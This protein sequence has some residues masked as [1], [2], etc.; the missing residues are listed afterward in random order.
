VTS[1]SASPI[2]VAITGAL[3]GAAVMTTAR[4]QRKIW[5]SSFER[6]GAAS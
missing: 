1:S 6:L 3:A 4:R 5:G 2:G